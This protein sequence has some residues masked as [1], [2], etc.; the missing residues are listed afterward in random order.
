LYADKE[1]EVVIAIKI[2]KRTTEAKISGA[3]STRP[4]CA[5]NQRVVGFERFGPIAFEKYAVLGGDAVE[6]LA[7][8]TA[9]VLRTIGVPE[10]VVSVTEA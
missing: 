4:I 8:R 10:T 2:K 1:I 3:E 7:I 5:R 9:L 6:A